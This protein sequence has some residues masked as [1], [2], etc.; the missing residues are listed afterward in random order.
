M[1]KLNS[2]GGVDYLVQWVK[3]RYLDVQV[4]QVGRRKLQK[5]PNQAIRDYVGEFDRSYARLVECGCTL[6]MGLR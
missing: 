6:P 5:K 3:D 1:D 2:L 4:T